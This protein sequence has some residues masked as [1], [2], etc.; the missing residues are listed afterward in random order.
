MKFTKVGLFLV[1]LCFIAEQ[2][3]EMTGYVNDIVQRADQLFVVGKGLSEQGTRLLA[4]QLA[5]MAIGDIEALLESNNVNPTQIRKVVEN[6][7]D[8]AI[9]LVKLLILF[10]ILK[11]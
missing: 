11:H 5:N 9:A 3:F 8:L 10:K 6:F 7:I 1:I 2:I 4:A